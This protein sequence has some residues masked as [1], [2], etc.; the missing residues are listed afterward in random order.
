[1]GIVFAL[2]NFLAKKKKETGN[3]LLQNLESE[4]I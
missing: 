2:R 4:I 1:M 3:E